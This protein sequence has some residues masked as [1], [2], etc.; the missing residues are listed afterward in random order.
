MTPTPWY[1]VK[2]YAQA[3]GNDRLAAQLWGLTEVELREIQD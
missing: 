1:T 3:G 2:K